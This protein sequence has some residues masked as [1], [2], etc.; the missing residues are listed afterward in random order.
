MIAVLSAIAM[1][2][3]DYAVLRYRSRDGFGVVQVQPYY[4][5]HL[6]NGKTE[7]MPG[8]ALTDTCVRSVFPQMGYSPCWY[9]NRQKRKTVDVQ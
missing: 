7:I 4:A 6:K 1:Y 2:A 8:D 5:V 3:L 9:A